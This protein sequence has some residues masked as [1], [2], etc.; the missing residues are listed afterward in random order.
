MERIEDLL[1]GLSAG[2]LLACIVKHRYD[3]DDPA[4][5]QA[6]DFD[7]RNGGKAIRIPETIEDTR[8]PR[9]VPAAAA[10]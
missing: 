1:I 6:P 3:K 2:F 8:R 9:A 7:S 4:R 5:Y 10:S